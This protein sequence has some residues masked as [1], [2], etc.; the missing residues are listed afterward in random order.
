MAPMAVRSNMLYGRSLLVCALVSI[1]HPLFADEASTSKRLEQAKRSEPELI[2]FLSRMPKGADLHNH[3]TG[4]I[5]SDFI[6]DNAVKQGLYF[7][8]KTSGFAKDSGD[9]RVPASALLTNNALLYQYLNKVS[10][11]G[12]YPN[13][14]SGHDHFFE[15]FDIIGSG[16]TGWSTEDLLVEVLRRNQMQSVQ[17]MELM[18]QCG[19][20][21]QLNA[22]YQ[23]PPPVDDFEKA[24]QALRPKM[25]ALAKA[26]PAYMNARAKT[27]AARL[28][29]TRPIDVRYIMQL[30]RLSTNSVFFSTACAAMTLMRADRRVVALNIVAPEDHPNARNNFDMQMKMLDWLWRRFG[31]PNITLHAGEL[32]LQYSPVEVM[33]DR[34]RK[35]IEVGHA[36]RI[37]HGV[38]IAW[39]RDLPGLFKE[40]REKGIMV[41]ICLTSNAS[42]LGVSGLE[43][44]FL[45]YR[46]A[47]IPLNL[48]T[49]DE[50]VSRS[51]LTNELVRAVRTYNLHY[52][53][54]KQLARNSIEFSFLPG[55]SLY[56]NRDYRKL[57][58]GFDGVRKPQWSPS[59]SAQGAMRQSDK[60]R[61]QVRLERAWAQFER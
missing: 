19:P 9:G 50:G 24:Y 11:R 36:K 45:L 23:D 7:D 20:S 41:E 60:L 56:R 18:T 49:D 43:H 12:W 5:Y 52:S 31:K 34:I 8:T 51:N 42:I 33:R 3:V 37:G 17:Y 54:L 53:D 38:S 28:D 25:A 58:K 44:P 46:R 57:I 30:N 59:I 27:L 6:L 55:Q 48:N 21:E 39:E 13:T 1:C 32:T 4:A 26:E 10:M 16:F 35:S 61:V 22:F 15:T 14:T 2:A 40:M 47:G 29:P